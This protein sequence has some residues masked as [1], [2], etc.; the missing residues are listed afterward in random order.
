MIKEVVV[1]DLV[2]YNSFF[3]YIFIDDDLL[4]YRQQIICIL[5]NDVTPKSK[6]YMRSYTVLYIF[7]YTY[8]SSTKKYHPYWI[9]Q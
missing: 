4:Q 1:Q 7:F 6:K 9:V 3:F 2:W 5:V 8:K